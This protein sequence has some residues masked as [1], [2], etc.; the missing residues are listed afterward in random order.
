[1]PFN[2][3][4]NRQEMKEGFFDGQ[5]NYTEFRQPK[6]Y[7]CYVS[8]TCCRALKDAWLDEVDE[9]FTKEMEKEADA[10][11][12]KW[13]EKQA[14]DMEASAKKKQEKKARKEAEEADTYALRAKILQLLQPGETALL[15]L[16]RYGK[17][18][19]CIF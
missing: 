5:G 15:A 8:L 6:Y 18:R 12:K 16:R 9:K 17:V 11:E 2:I 7:S 1:M 14:A 10:L 3:A 4:F 19:Y 13:R